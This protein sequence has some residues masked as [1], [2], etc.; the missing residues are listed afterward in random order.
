ME[1]QQVRSVIQRALVSFT[2]TTTSAGNAG[3][4]TLVCS[5][6]T[7]QADF[8]RQQ[9]IITS[10]AY[11]GKSADIVGAT[12]GGTVTM[13]PA[14]GAQIGSGVNFVIMTGL[15]TSSEIG[16]PSGDTLTSIAAK[17]GDIAR[18]L[19]AILGARWDTSG[20]LGTD[21]G[22]MLYKAGLVHYGVVASI[23][24]ANTFIVTEFI[25]LGSGKFA[26]A[27]NPYQVFVLRD[28]GGA[29]AAPQGELQPVTA[30]N[31]TTGQI[32][33]SA[34]TAALVATDEILL[35]HPMIA[36]ILTLLN[37]LTAAR[38]GYLDNIN[39]AN[40]A[41]IA[42]ISTFDATKIG[43]LDELA[44]ANLPTDIAALN[45]LLSNA[46][47]GLAALETLVDDLES[48]LTAAR[49][50]Y[51]DELDFDLDA[52]LGSPA[53]GSISADILAIDNFVDELESR[54]SAVRAGYLDNLSAG[55]VA[56]AATALSTA[57]W[58]N[59]RAVYLDLLQY[60]YSLNCTGATAGSIADR[61]ID[62]GTAVTAILADTGTDGVVVNAYTNVADRVAGKK[63]VIEVSV[64]SAANAGDV[65][66]AT[67]TTQPCVIESI[68]IHADAAQTGDLTSA[69]IFGGAA[70]VITFIAAADALQA[71]LDAEDKQV[72]WEGAVRLAAAKTIIISLVGTGAT[73]VNLTVTIT[74]RS[75]VDNG[76][77]A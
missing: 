76:Y 69:G 44:A 75:C 59:G 41:T 8:D 22:A 45:T 63:Q 23:P 62:I 6:L 56:L 33:H 71:D 25:G 61:I 14:Y 58:T 50:G 67:I 66:L 36:G 73:A 10:G 26:G 51:L 77:L 38:A 37:R 48:R 3:G 40:L 21:I 42:D 29:A 47:Y 27:T 2:G 60:L 35:V 68:V 53:G 20:D 65:T 55:A 39:N 12:T 34:F 4:S 28:A 52:R 9:I 24:G 43:Y 74:Y 11:T 46:T 1:A 16:D 19:D 49:A 5:A 54:L 30:F 15:P 64:T 18:S 7:S 17:W 13:S 32:D 57:Q 31:S 70:K 72:S